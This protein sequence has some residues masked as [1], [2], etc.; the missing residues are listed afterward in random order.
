MACCPNGSFPPSK[1]PPAEAQRHTLL[2]A[3][4]CSLLHQKI[5]VSSCQQRHW[6]DVPKDD[7]R[8]ASDPS[9]IIG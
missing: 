1:A 9:F 5:P 7:G 2:F 3:L 6:M 4:E 8:Y